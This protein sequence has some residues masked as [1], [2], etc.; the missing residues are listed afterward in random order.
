M[1][2]RRS[3]T[4]SPMIAAS[5]EMSWSTVPLPAGAARAASTES[6]ETAA[7]ASATLSARA[8]KRSFLA[9]KSVSQA[10]SRSV[11]LPPTSRA[12][13]SPSLVERSARLAL[14]FAPLR[15]RISTAF[16]TSPSA[17]SSAFFVSTMPVPSCS[18]NALMSAIVKF[19]MVCEPLAVSLVCRGC[20][21]EGSP[22]GI[23]PGEPTRLFGGGR[24]GCVFGG[25]HISGVETRGLGDRLV[26]TGGA[27]GVSGGTALDGLLVGDELARDGRGERELGDLRG[28]RG[29]LLGSSLLE[30]LALPVSEGLGRF[31]LTRGLVA[32]D[33]TLGSGVGDDAGEQAHR[34]DRIVVTGDRVLE[35][36][37]VGV[38][39]EDAD[40]GDA[41]LLCL[42]D[43]EVLALG[44]DDPDRRGRLGQVAD[45]AERLVQLVELALL[46]QQFLLGEA[47]VRGNLVVELFELLHTS[48]TLRDRLEV[49]EQTAEPTL[50]DVGL[51]DTGRLLGD[52]ALGLLL[53]AD[54]EHGA[55]TGDRLLD[56]VVRLV[57]VRQRLLQVDDVDAAALGE[58]EALHLRV[59]PTRLVSEVHARIEQLA[60]GNDGHGRLL[61]WH[62]A[63]PLA[64]V[65][66]RSGW[67]TGLV[68]GTLPPA[69][70]RDRG[71]GVPRAI[72]GSQRSG[73]AKSPRK[74]GALPVYQPQTA[75]WWP[76]HTAPPPHP[77]GA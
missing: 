50:V 33:Q 47:T 12:T 65:I 36:V 29:G 14:P 40:H 16:S 53:R 51:A 9:T 2:T 41:E 3:S 72:L 71:E 55:A 77:N 45:S 32:L 76:S 21:G 1:R 20:R 24:R 56:E 34:A 54:E 23:P 4:F 58:D 61:S 17:S 69:V 28:V 52:D 38:G 75:T 27:F 35:L 25:L 30:Q 11:T 64:V 60:N 66:R 37:R 68:P 63:V 70:R 44:V 19:A 59:P 39:V 13:T 74:R 10:S 8:M 73:H 31:G 26:V 62:Y 15:R 7:A 57:D 42:V 43:R 6:A 18:R 67:A 46:D 48:K 5:S 22:D 49:G